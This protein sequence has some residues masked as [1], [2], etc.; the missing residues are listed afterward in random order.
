M[1]KYDMLDLVGE[2]AYGVVL[3]CRRKDTG[4]LVAIKTFKGNEESTNVKRTIAREI[5][6]LKNLRHENIVLLKE[7]FRWKGKLHLV[8]EYIQKNLLEI[9]EASPSGLDQETVRL[10]IWQLV[11]ALNHCHRNDVV[12][13]DIKP[14]NLLVNPKTRKLKLCDFGFARQLH[15]AGGPLTDYVATRWYR[16]PE[17]LLGDSE[18]GSPVDM[19]AVGCIMGELIDGQPLFPGDNE[20]DQLYKIQLVLGPLLP[21]HMKMFKENPRFTGL[22]FPALPPRETLLLRYHNKFDKI[23]IDFMS[24]LLCMD[25]AKRLTAKMALQH[26]YLKELEAKEREE[27]VCHPAVAEL[28]ATERKRHTSSTRSSQ[29]SLSSSVCQ[30]DSSPAVA[31]SQASETS[32]YPGHSQQPSPQRSEQR[33]SSRGQPVGGLLT[34][35][36]QSP[37][38]LPSDHDMAQGRLSQKE[39]FSGG[40]IFQHHQRAHADQQ[41]ANGWGRA[42]LSLQFSEE[43]PGGGSHAEPSHTDVRRAASRNPAEQKRHREE[44]TSQAGAHQI[45]LEE[46]MEHRGLQWRAADD[47]EQTG[48]Q[49][50][51]ELSDLPLRLQGPFEHLALTN[52]R[53][54]GEVPSSVR[55]EPQG[56]R[57]DP[58]AER[59]PGCISPETARGFPQQVA[60]PSADVGDVFQTPGFCLE[61]ETLE[62]PGMPKRKAA[63]PILPLRLAEEAEVPGHVSAGQ[64]QADSIRTGSTL[65]PMSERQLTEVGTQHGYSPD[66]GGSRHQSEAEVATASGSHAN[67]NVESSLASSSRELS[68]AQRRESRNRC[69]HHS[70]RAMSCIGDDEVANGAPL[71]PNVSPPAAF[72]PVDSELGSAVVA[73]EPQE[74]GRHLL[75]ADSLSRASQQGLPVFPPSVDH[76]A[77]ARA[78]LP[79]VYLS[80]NPA[81]CRGRPLFAQQSTDAHQIPLRHACSPGQMAASPQA[82]RTLARHTPPRSGDRLPSHEGQQAAVGNAPDRGDVTQREGNPAWRDVTRPRS[83]SSVRAPES[84]AAS[85]P[86]PLQSRGDRLDY[87]WEATA[88][89]SRRSGQQERPACASSADRP[90]VERHTLNTEAGLPVATASRPSP[91]KSSQNLTGCGQAVDAHAHEPPTAFAPTGSLRG[92]TRRRSRAD[93]S[94]KGAGDKNS[95]ATSGPFDLR[96]QAP[97]RRSTPDCAS[98]S[99]A[100]LRRHATDD[101]RRRAAAPRKRIQ[102]SQT[103]DGRARSDSSVPAGDTPAQELSGSG[104]RWTDVPVGGD[105]RPAALAP[106]KARGDTQ[107]SCSSSSGGSSRVSGSSAERGGGLPGHRTVRG[108]R[109]G[110]S[111][112]SRTISQTIPGAATTL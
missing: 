12:H 71:P 14:E 77:E 30:P 81:L 105:G 80:G 24:K 35:K 55:S 23:A 63:L 112:R 48:R 4:E 108:R 75:S 6:A 37:P 89:Q 60:R 95:C 99:P 42:P 73:F 85:S 58:S 26:P 36:I 7:A 56:E 100:R 84:Q 92:S 11:K 39:L 109:V 9:L 8:F 90:C 97:H 68:C 106:K 88:H 44:A 103:Q 93:V 2:G 102:M 13:R 98:A 25:P 31:L 111:R 17:L 69:G 66:A 59:L 21:H 47:Q 33:S 46:S 16:S 67:N 64:R 5:N 94:M 107:L 65:P 15:D 51:A 101:H 27:R 19:W 20:V 83:S 28:L 79:A 61:T 45:L 3:K 1:N 74:A 82:L 72:L 57:N 18:Y 78:C 54:K 34:V 96:P 22:A 76:A 104:P 29:S 86:P 110:G 41:L 53:D 43:M 38:R 91:S 52:T 32:P 10:C 50:H 40:N 62:E 70:A 49:H 87:L